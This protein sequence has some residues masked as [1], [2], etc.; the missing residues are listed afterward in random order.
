MRNRAAVVLPFG[1]T[2]LLEELRHPALPGLWQL[3]LPGGGIEPGETPRET[4]VRELAEEFGL[5]VDPSQLQYKGQVSTPAQVMHVF[6][7]PTHPLEPGCYGREADNGR[8][9]L[10]APA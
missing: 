5:L 6:E 1:N 2:I 9:H 10:I 3:R 8:T 4:I 7:W